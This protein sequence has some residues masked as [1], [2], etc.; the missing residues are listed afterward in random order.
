MSV[1][2]REA[3]VQFMEA[4]RNDII[5][6]HI[7]QGQRV[8]GKTLESLEIFAND[9]YGSL[10]AFGYIG[11]LEDGRKPG[12]APPVGRIEQWINDRGILPKGKISRLQLAFIIARKISMLGTALFQNG[13]GSG[14]LSKAINEGRINT[15]L[16]A[17][18]EK[19][20]TEFSSEVI[21]EFK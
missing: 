18:G 14:V 11:V 21:S 8:T 10:T 2:N 19:Y 16:E 1:S 3:I 5:A 13:G 6:E 7:R 20:I 12:K 4:I 15:L 9:I 17:M